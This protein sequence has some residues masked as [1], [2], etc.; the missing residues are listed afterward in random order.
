[1]YCWS[2]STLSLSHSFWNHHSSLERS[3]MYLL[4][5]H[6]HICSFG[7]K[8]RI[9]NQAE[10]KNMYIL[11]FLKML[12]R[13]VYLHFL[14]LLLLFPLIIVIFTIFT[15]SHFEIKPFNSVVGTRAVVLFIF[16]FHTIV[17]TV[18]STCQQLESRVVLEHAWPRTSSFFT[19]SK[20][21]RTL[22]SST[23]LHAGEREREK[24]NFSQAKYKR[25]FTYPP[26]TA[27]AADKL[28]WCEVAVGCSWGCST[29]FCLHSHS[30]QTWFWAW[31]SESEN[32]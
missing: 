29:H 10:D 18:P 11:Q 5:Q 26:R 32:E 13:F 31:G 17:F 19:G 21:Q 20:S 12:A 4:I 23:A 30:Y 15:G 6:L 8:G 3:T 24:K 9:K 25:L 2:S 16:L 7:Q 14:I 1:M 27:K 28:C 22:S